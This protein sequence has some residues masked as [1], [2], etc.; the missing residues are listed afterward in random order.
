MS[1]VYMVGACHS[2][3]TPFDVE[4]VAVYGA[5]DPDKGEDCLP[6]HLNTAASARYAA[7]SRLEHGS[8]GCSP[9]RPSL[10]ELSKLMR[11]AKHRAKVSARVLEESLSQNYLD[12]RPF[13]LAMS[14]RICRGGGIRSRVSRAIPSGSGRHCNSALPELP[15]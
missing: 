13:F 1:L 11:P 10:E 8:T 15:R 4:I 5:V 14:C 9:A 7:L 6:A 12:L 3:D 2:R